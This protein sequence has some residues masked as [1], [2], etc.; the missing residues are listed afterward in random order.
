VDT[1]VTDVI[2]VLKTGW[3]DAYPD[4]AICEADSN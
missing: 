2:A 3:P 1:I 4:Q